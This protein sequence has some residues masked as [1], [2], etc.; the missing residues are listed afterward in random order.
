MQLNPIPVVT[1]ELWQDPGSITPGAGDTPVIDWSA[2]NQRIPVVEIQ[3]G[4]QSVATNWEAFQA[5]MSLNPGVRLLEKAI[6]SRPTF[7]PTPNYDPHQFVQY[8]GKKLG[9]VPE[10][11]RQQLLN[12]ASSDEEAFYITSQFN[13]RQQAQQKAYG[14]PFVTAAAGA[15][16]PTEIPILALT[17]GAS[18]A[19]RAGRASALAARGGTALVGGGAFGGASYAVNEYSQDRLSEAAVAA[20]AGAVGNAIAVQGRAPKSLTAGQ[21]AR[22]GASLT[23]KLPDGVQRGLAKVQ[24]LADEVKLY[25]QALGAKLFGSTDRYGIDGVVGM[26]RAVAQAM[27]VDLV[28]F[29]QAMKK[30]NLGGTFNPLKFAEQRLRTESVMSSVDEA[31]AKLHDAYS[32]GGQAAADQLYN[33]MRMDAPVK[34]LVDAYVGS[35]FANKALDR[36]KNAGVAGADEVMPSPYYVPRKFSPNK[37]FNE[38][39][40]QF[41]KAQQRE[42]DRVAK[43]FAKD[44]RPDYM[45]EEE[46]LNAMARK[47][48]RQLL[49]NATD[50]TPH[51]ERAVGLG[52]LRNIWGDMPG[53]NTLTKAIQKLDDEALT[54]V[55][56][57]LQEATGLE[58]EAIENLLS[59]K[60]TDS[61][62]TVGALGQTATNLRRRMDFDMFEDSEGFSLFD[63]VD[64]DVYGK[65]EKYKLQTSTRI[66]LAQGGFSNAAKYNSA[67]SEL[68]DT[69]RTRGVPEEVINRTVGHTDAIITGKG[70]G[71]PLGSVARALSTTAAATHLAMSAIYNIADYAFVAYEHGM[72]N[73]AKAF[74][75]GIKPEVWKGITKADAED[76]LEIVKLRGYTDGRIKPEIKL[77]EDNWT[78]NAGS[79]AIAFTDHMG[80]ATRYLNGSEYMRR[81][82]INMMAELLSQRLHTGLKAGGDMSYFEQM[83]MSQAK[84]RGFRELYAKHGLNLKD[85]P[86]KAADEL[87]RY[88]NASIDHT[89]LAIRKGQ[90][91][92][93][94]DTQVGKVLMP[95]MSFVWAA[96]NQ[97]MRRVYKNDGAAG[98]AHLMIMQAPLAL[99]AAA[100][101]NI[102]K[103]KEWD[104]E[105]QANFTKSM[106]S[107]GLASIMMDFVNRGKLGDAPTVFAPVNSA[108]KLAQVVSG[109]DTSMADVVKNLPIL[110][111]T[112]P[113][114]LVASTLGDNN[115]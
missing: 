59:I 13:E 34:D 8:I 31:L 95:Y 84:Q 108:A 83:G 6:I 19:I 55:R 52:M 26:Q 69:M 91:P 73:T 90:R 44:V 3:P 109:A 15:V 115:E 78:L 21:Q 5:S 87:L 88:T 70:I 29:E 76:L 60:T 45:L 23:G 106:S 49:V 56:L 57:R 12:E 103:G 104:D 97:V 11:L 27:D 85:W 7:E 100:A 33:L 36:L 35:G 24:S 43:G 72:W 112:L 98:V 93:L 40:V 41:K 71:E 111:V 17:G 9:P 54:I 4:A 51:L 46:A 63:L 105:L 28:P 37:V 50:V 102:V 58:K 64:N 62:P 42:A 67:I 107:L 10:E 20:V 101:A 99:I 2:M 38:F 18:A 79:T 16:D 82:Q 89:V 14:N 92:A 22:L 114:R 53:M 86:L 48:G 1:D 65:L 30:H 66:G 110:G 94:L 32:R 74:M 113:V 39:K 80:Q 75:K 81:H 47:F 68:A 96:H 77:M 25:N 61:V